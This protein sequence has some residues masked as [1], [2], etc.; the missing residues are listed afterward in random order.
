MTSVFCIY[1][2]MLDIYGGGISDRVIFFG[3]ASKKGFLVKAKTTT[4]WWVTVI[5]QHH[6]INNYIVHCSFPTLDLIVYILHTFWKDNLTLKN[7]RRRRKAARHDYHTSFRFMHL[8]SLFW[9]QRTYI[10]VTSPKRYE[11]SRQI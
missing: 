3:E 11:F 7:K 10:Y 6:A 1:F 8:I 5:V 9:N 4:I 2:F